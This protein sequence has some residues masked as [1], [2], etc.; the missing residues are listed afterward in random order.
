[1]VVRSGGL[2]QAGPRACLSAFTL[3]RGLCSGPDHSLNTD[4][5]SGLGF[6]GSL[7][8]S[9]WRSATTGPGGC[10]LHPSERQA[11]GKPAGYQLGEHV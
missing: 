3:C 7:S 10:C 11:A 2:L 8:P 5:E 6:G 9:A 4:D 1:M